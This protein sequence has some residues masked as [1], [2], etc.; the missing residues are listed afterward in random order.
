[1]TEQLE[2]SKVQPREPDKCDC[3]WSEWH[4]AQSTQANRQLRDIEARAKLHARDLARLRIE[5]EKAPKARRKCA[6]PALKPNSIHRFLSAVPRAVARG[7][8]TAAQGNGLLYA[9]QTYIALLRS[10]APPT[11]TPG[12]MGFASAKSREE[13]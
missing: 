13:K 8:I 3:K 12:R 10:A 7:E 5:L 9:A 6:I 4:R 2:L 1:M 11:P